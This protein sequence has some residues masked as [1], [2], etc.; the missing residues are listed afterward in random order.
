MPHFNR[1]FGQYRATF[2]SPS[3]ADAFEKVQAA[4]RAAY[5][6]SQGYTVRAVKGSREWNIY[7]HKGLTTG[8]GI[9]F[10]PVSSA[11][12]PQQIEIRV[13][14]HSRLMQLAFYPMYGVGGGLVVLFYLGNLAGWWAGNGLNALLI[15]ALL[16][17]AF[18][19]GVA[20]IVGGCTYIGGRWSNN[21]L[22]AIGRTV[23]EAIEL[24]ATQGCA[25]PIATLKNER[26]S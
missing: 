3:P 18:V 5:L 17:I 4:M 8:F 11:F 24:S 16:A 25:E 1:L 13:G 10:V 22:S 15:G 26:L 21:Q 12:G 7:V 23:G 14:R 6:P 9:D 19:F 20:G 2:E